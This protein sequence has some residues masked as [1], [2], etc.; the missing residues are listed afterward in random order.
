M[1]HWSKTFRRYE[2]HFLI[3]LVV[4]L[5]AA[6]S[7]TG[8]ISRCSRLEGGGHST[9]QKI[10]GSFQA[11]PKKRVEISDDEMVERTREIS[12]FTAVRDNVLTL[13]YER[14]D[15]HPKNRASEV[16]KQAWM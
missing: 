3:A 9:T 16:A 6:F 5:L 8:A 15:L 1:A 7:V 2:R 13:E 14:F 11:T 10:G 12:A 4:L